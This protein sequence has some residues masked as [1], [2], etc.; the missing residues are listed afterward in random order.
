MKDTEQRVTSDYTVKTIFYQ[1]GNSIIPIKTTQYGIRNDLVYIN[2][3]DDEFTSVE[4]TRKLLEKEGG[5]LIEL[6]NKGRRDLRFRIGNIYYRVDPNRIFSPEGIS[7]SLREKRRYSIKASQEVAKLGQRIVQLFPKNPLCIIALH[8]NTH[9][10]FSINDYLPGNIRAQDAAKV[11]TNPDQDPDDLFITTNRGIYN[12]LTR[13]KYNSVLQDNDNCRQDG[14]LSVYCGK[15]NIQYVNLETEH[16]KYDQY[17]EMI[18]YLYEVITT[19]DIS[20]EEYYFTAVVSSDTKLP[21]AGSLI[22]F[23]NKKIGKINSIQ[24]PDDNGTISGTMLIN[25]DF[26]LFS[27]MSFYFLDSESGNPRYEIRIDPTSEKKQL[28]P[29]D[30]IVELIVKIQTKSSGN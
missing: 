14:S 29:V 15:K 18:G 7:T 3:H 4:A 2:L 11:Y 24:Q 13:K 21:G 9:D 30:D 28:N 23:G 25:N 19:K 20:S 5:L 27:N 12:Y 22:Y 1:L 16:G 8:N 10:Y 26:P 6:E 17:A